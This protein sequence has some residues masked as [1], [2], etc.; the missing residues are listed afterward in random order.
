MQSAQSTRLVVFDCDGTL[1]D[2][3][4]Q[5]T[6]AMALAFREHGYPEPTLRAVRAI[7]GL[8]PLE[9]VRVLLP[10]APPQ[11]IEAIATVFRQA[12]FHL[13]QQPDYHEPLFPGTLEALAHLEAAG[14]LLGVATGKTRRGLQATLSAH[15]LQRRFVTLQTADRHPGKPDPSMLLEAMAEAGSGPEHTV[16][17]GDTTFD[18][19]MAQQARVPAVGVAWGYHPAAA[20]EQAGAIRVI[21]DY[22]HLPPLAATLTGA[23]A[24]DHASS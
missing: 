3:Q 16:L 2:S 9:A 20:L 24:C 5:I 7:I 12:F 23:A 1:V 21:D 22:A 19:L 6:A 4:H 15:G 17:V 11:R 13:R 8:S 10:Q 18:V 14:F